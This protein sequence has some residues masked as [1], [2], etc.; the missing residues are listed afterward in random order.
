MGSRAWIIMKCCEQNSGL[1]YA[2]LSKV[3]YIEHKVSNTFN[4]YYSCYYMVG[5][6]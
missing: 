4:K 3:N 6:L 2:L 1:T 5:Y